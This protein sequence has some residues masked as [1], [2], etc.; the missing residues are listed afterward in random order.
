M[1]KQFKKLFEEELLQP[2]ISSFLL[3][4]TSSKWNLG[5]LDE[6][7]IFYCNKIPL[8]DGCRGCSTVAERTPRQQDIMGSNPAF[9]HMWSVL[10]QVPQVS[11]S[12][13]RTKWNI[14][15][16]GCLGWKRLKFDDL[17]KKKTF[18]SRLL[19]QVPIRLL[20]NGESLQCKRNC[21]HPKVCISLSHLSITFSWDGV[22]R[23]PK[24]CLHLDLLNGWNNP[25]VAIVSLQI[26]SQHEKH[27]KITN[28]GLIISK[29]WM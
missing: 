17:E 4:V 19:K 13:S 16:N 15:K 7:D 27:D 8:V 1:S 5:I 23:K 3:W 20:C 21:H 6:V 25:W 28:W 18:H 12:L 10:Y 9:H 14:M 29:R 24:S 22:A 26:N 11:T 2:G